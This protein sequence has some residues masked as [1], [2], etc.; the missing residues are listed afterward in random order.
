MAKTEQSNARNERQ[1]FFVVTAED[2]GLPPEY[3][4]VGEVTQGYDTVERID[5][6]GDADEQPSQPVVIE[7]VTV[8]KVTA[9][10][11]AR[12]WDR[13]WLDKLLH[14]H[15]EPSTVVLSVLERL[16]PGRGA[17][18]RLRLRPARRVARRARAGA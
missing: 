18:P 5:A 17:R 15:G 11:D 16:R 14:A 12:E 3:A 1:P 13:R 4:I 7:R 8:R 10:M 2:A 6:L 9:S